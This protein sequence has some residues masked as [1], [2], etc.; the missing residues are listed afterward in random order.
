MLSFAGA[1]LIIVIVMII[2]AIYK[3]PVSAASNAHGTS[4]HNNLNNITSHEP[5]NR[6]KIIVM[7]KVILQFKGL[8]S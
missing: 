3:A 4:L 7:W 2:M 5:I 6:Q 8:G 1:I